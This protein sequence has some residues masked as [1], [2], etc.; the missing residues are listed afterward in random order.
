MKV[1]NK[2]QQFSPDDF[3]EI[4]FSDTW[5]LLSILN[6][7]WVSTSV[8][9]APMLKCDDGTN[10]IVLLPH[11]S[12]RVQL[13]KLAIKQDNGDYFN[14]NGD[15]TANIGMEYLK[16]T[17]WEVKP[18]RKGPVPANLKY[19]LPEGTQTFANEKFSIDGEY[20][21]AQDVKGKVLPKALRVYC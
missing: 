15:V 16:V 13:A 19:K 14:K 1:T 3:K 2:H 7:R 9:I 8:G 17:E 5:K 10:D 20:Y 4:T 12:S 6:A 11:R 18:S 21:P